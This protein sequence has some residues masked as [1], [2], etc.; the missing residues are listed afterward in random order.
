MPTY[1]GFIPVIDSLD[2]YLIVGCDVVGDNDFER[3]GIKN[4]NTAVYKTTSLKVVRTSNLNSEF[5]RTKQGIYYSL[6]DNLSKSKENGVELSY[7]Q[8]TTNEKEKVKYFSTHFA[9]TEY[10]MFHFLSKLKFSHLTTKDQNYHYILNYCKRNQGLFRSYYENGQVCE[11]FIMEDF[12]RNGRYQSFDKKG[13]KTRDCLYKDDKL[14]GKCTSY[15]NVDLIFP[16]MKKLEENIEE[17]ECEETSTD[18]PIY[19]EPKV[20]Q[21]EK[22]SHIIETEYEYGYETGYFTSYLKN[23]N[24]ERFIEGYKVKGKNDGIIYKYST[25]K[26]NIVMRN[27]YNIGKLV[28]EETLLF[29]GPEEENANEDEKNITF[30]EYKKINFQKYK[31]NLICAECI[32]KGDTEDNKKTFIIL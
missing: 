1:S 5:A 13:N 21:K 28:K 30:D 32:E 31:D 18:E 17:E 16:K 20:I 10:I 23:D 19:T 14:H 29:V 4:K 8:Y 24:E 15:K 7:D 22:E 27:L 11:M 9:A 3:K 25:K 2:R 6:I 26:P 12:K